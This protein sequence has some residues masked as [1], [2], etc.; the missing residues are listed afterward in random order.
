MNENNAD[1]TPAAPNF[2]TLVRMSFQ[3]L[4]NFPYIEEDFDALTNYEL[5]S[6]VV[7]YLNQVISNN[8]EQNTLMTNLY[9]AYVSLQ[10]YVNNYFNNLDVQEEINNK[11]DEMAESG[12]LGQVFEQ[13]VNPIMNVQDAKITNLQRQVNGLASGSPIPVSSTSQMTNTSKIYVLTTDGNW[14]YYNGSAWVSGGTYQSTGIGDGEVTFDNFN[15]YLS[16]SLFDY[17]TDVSTLGWVFSSSGATAQKW[18]NPIYI[19]KGTTITVSDDFVTNYKWNIK[20]YATNKFS[21]LSDVFQYT[22]ETSYITTTDMLCVF[23]YRPIDDDWTTEEY[24][25][26]RFAKLTNSDITQIKYYFPIKNGFLL[27][28]I[29]SYMLKANMGMGGFS[30]G[31]KTYQPVNTR[32][33]TIALFKSAYPIKFHVESGFRYGIITWNSFNGYGNTNFESDTG[34]L[35]EDYTL[36]ANKI[37][38]YTLSKIDSTTLA[39]VSDLDNKVTLT[40][41]ANFNYVDSYIDN[42][43]SG[44]G[45]Y[46]YTG[47]KIDFQD[48]YG[49]DYDRLIAYT[50]INNSQGFDIYNGYIVQLYADQKIRIINMSTGENEGVIENVIF[51][52]GDTCQF[53]NVKYDE[54]DM[55]PLLY[56]TSDLTPSVVHIVRIIDNSTASVIK[57][58]DLGIEAGYYAGH[59]FDF[60]NNILYSFGYKIQN[61]TSSENNA[62]IISV[63]NMNNETLISDSTYSLEL[64][65]RYEK[66]FIYCIQGQKF[67]KGKCYLVSSYNPAVSPNVIYVYD[68]IRKLITSEFRN[69]P[70]SL[71]GSELEDIAFVLNSETKYYNMIIGNRSYYYVLSFM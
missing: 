43:I 34:W 29:N 51:N 42:R 68:P 62:T 36:P 9:N 31:D 7:E 22:T 35:T 25:V 66:P 70:S 18:S 37:F 20:K 38:S 45:T 26:D 10:D 52:H 39:G 23:A 19:K 54:S 67:F 13:Y 44:I 59:C 55:F 48:S 41:Y 28:D 16:D 65:E 14:Y 46:N 30:A 60:N 33:S 69:L 47:E 71:G 4:T 64:I 8:N 12:Y 50:E 57:S 61:F 27:E 56:V 32:Y 2:K 49:Y 58:Y 15:A 1:F 21:N 3:G 40:S 63:Y 17:S 5:L 24:T 11:L 6:K 53:S